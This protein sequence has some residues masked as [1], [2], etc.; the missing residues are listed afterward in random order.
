MVDKNNSQDS[1]MEDQVHTSETYRHI[2]DQ[3]ALELLTTASGTISTPIIQYPINDTFPVKMWVF[4]QHPPTQDP[5]KPL[6]PED[7]C[8]AIKAIN[9]HL[10]PSERIDVEQYL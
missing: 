1:I 7:E 2:S 4:E 8:K 9:R 10:P 3:G 6:Q 5:F